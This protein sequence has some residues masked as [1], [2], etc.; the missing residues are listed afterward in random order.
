MIYL[1]SIFFKYLFDFNFF[2]KKK[3]I[4][5]HKDLPALLMLI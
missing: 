4:K 1:K 3:E 5:F 2:L